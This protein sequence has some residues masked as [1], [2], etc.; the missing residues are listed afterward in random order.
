M[1]EFKTGW[2]RLTIL[3]NSLWN[4]DL[5]EVRELVMVNSPSRGNNRAKTRAKGYTFSA[6]TF[7]LISLALPKKNNFW[8]SFYGSKT[9]IMFAVV[10]YLF[11]VDIFREDFRY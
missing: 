6:I 1:V 8:H 7:S 3:T 11:I 5:K 4:K 2:S 10:S 9:P